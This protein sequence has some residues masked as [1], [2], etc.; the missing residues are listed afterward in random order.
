MLLRHFG[1][2][3]HD[4]ITQLLQICWLHIHNANLLFHPKGALLASIWCRGQIWTHCHVQKTSLRSFEHCDMLH[5]PAGG[6]HQKMHC[7]VVIKGGT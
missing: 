2:Y 1:P 7:T 5:Y 6:G 3:F 4:N